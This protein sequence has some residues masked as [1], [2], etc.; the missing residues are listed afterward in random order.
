MLRYDT[1]PTLSNYT[2]LVEYIEKQSSFV[3]Q[4]TLYGYIKTRAGT[5]WPKLFENEKYLTSLKIARWH[6]F[7]ACVADLSLFAAAQFHKSGE[8]DSKICAKLAYKITASILS[9]INQED[10]EETDFLA[11][12]KN[13]QKRYEETDYAEVATGD[14]AFQTSAQALLD[15]AP[16]IDDFKK[17][18]ALIV[19]NS[20]H[21]R[22][23][24]VRRD[25]AK[26]LQTKPILAEFNA[27]SA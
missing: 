17:N 6:I 20:L 23:I 22:W 13:S 9:D 21:L 14:S 19:R 1:A 24:G 26:G 16:V 4:V 25:L 7:A 5:Q 8:A 27:H 3:S 12:I 15:Y 2:H 10:I 18:D 11:V